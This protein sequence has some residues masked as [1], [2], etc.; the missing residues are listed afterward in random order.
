MYTLLLLNLIIPFV[1]VL[2]GSILKKYP[3]SD[4]ESQNGYNTPTSR[5]SQAHW[6]YAQ[7]IAPNIYISFGK[8]LGIIETVLSVIMFLF[9]TST[10]VALTVGACIGFGFL[11]LGFYKTD[12]EIK[13][14]FMES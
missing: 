11:F 13:K 12:A 10:Q 8:I 3:A 14:K 2:V 9:H 1:M 4:M 6:D 7:H 5:K